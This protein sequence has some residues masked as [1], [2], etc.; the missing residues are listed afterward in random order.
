MFFFNFSFRPYKQL[1]QKNKNYFYLQTPSKTIF[2]LLHLY[3]N[4]KIGS[5]LLSI[6]KEFHWVIADWMCGQREPRFYGH[7]N[8]QQHR[9]EQ[10]AQEKVMGFIVFRQSK[11]GQGP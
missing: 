2:K 5:F 8:D 1:Y 7:V 4:L 9:V 6:Q 3:L 11:H 10:R